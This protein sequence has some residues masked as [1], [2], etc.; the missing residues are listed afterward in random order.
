[1]KLSFLLTSLNK[2]ANDNDLSTPYL[3]GGLV[4]DRA[5]GKPSQIKD[6]DI[7][8][9]DK[10]SLSLAM[11]T[12]QLWKTAHFKLYDDGH[13]SIA[14]KNIRV[15]FSNNY[16]IPDIQ[17]ELKKININNPTE[18]QKE[19]FSRDFTI[20][21]LLQPLDLTK[22]T[23][24][25]TGRA[26]KDINKKY[27]RTPIDARLT[28]GHDPRRIIRAIKLATKYDLI[29]MPSLEDAILKYRGSLR[30]VPMG[31]I[32]SQINEILKI[33]SKKTLDILSKYKLL[34]ILPLSNLMAREVVNN[35][36][37]EQFL[38]E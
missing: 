19:M 9:G 6:I 37:V 3:V 15:D 27:L 31:W 22:D 10:N 1:M 7:T 17:R 2:I 5:F 26:L 36:M 29:I 21:C 14:F 16:N 32:K 30:D 38:E 4:R 13:S 25:I 33:N 20:N 11:A 18:L 28:I 8:T 24:D 23:I 35:K 12:A 34:P